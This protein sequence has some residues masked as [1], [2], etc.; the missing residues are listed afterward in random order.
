MIRRL[1]LLVLVTTS[2][3]NETVHAD[4]KYTIQSEAELLRLPA[5][6]R[7]T[8]QIREIS[9]D[10][11]PIS[12]YIQKYGPGYNHLHH[13]CWSL[14]QEYQAHSISDRAIARSW[15]RSAIGGIDY[16]LRNNHDPSF[17]FLPDIYVTRA[18][19]LFQLEDD[20]N[21]VSA[22]K[23]AIELRPSYVPAYSRLSDYYVEKGNT[24][25]AVRILKQGIAKSKKSDMLTRKLRELQ[26]K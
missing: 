6:C 8:Q 5:Y 1:S 7:G 9:R 22:L 21:A 16:V 2:L 17:V 20:P 13:Y 24:S 11:I 12:T 3:L 15:L 14:N 18:R 26:V 25:E 19:I 4:L 10:P 23:K